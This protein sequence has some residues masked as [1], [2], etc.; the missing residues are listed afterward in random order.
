MS[1]AE[2]ELCHNELCARGPVGAWSEAAPTGGGGRQLEGDIA[3][4]AE[5]YLTKGRFD[6]FAHLPLAGALL[7]PSDIG[8]MTITAQDGTVIATGARTGYEQGYPNG[9]ACSGPIG[10]RRILIEPELTGSAPTP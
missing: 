10:C 1:G 6:A 9:E 5:V 8:R 4:E 3:G 2:L 7:A